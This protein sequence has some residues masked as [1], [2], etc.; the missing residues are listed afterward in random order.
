MSS[1]SAASASV[2][3]SSP[4]VDSYIG[5][6]IS[7]TSK[8]EIRYE[9]VLANINPK[10]STIALQNVK[11]FGT[12]GR[13][14][15]GP[16]IPP[17]DKVYEYILFRGTDIKDLQVKSSS[18][19]N[20]KQPVETHNDPAI[21]QSHYVPAPTTHSSAAPAPTT[22][23]SSAAPHGDGPLA[24]PGSKTAQQDFPRQPF[25][26]AYSMYHAGSHLSSWAPSPA[27][28]IVDGPM[29]Y[30]GYG[31]SSSSHA[32]GHQSVPFQP[33]TPGMQN[34]LQYPE[35][36]AATRMPNFPETA[37]SLA[38][39]N[40]FAVSN[41]QYSSSSN[42]SLSSSLPSHLQAM[43]SL[44]SS[45][46]D[47]NTMGLMFSKAA[48]AQIS[49][50][51]VPSMPFSL[52]SN[53]GSNS[54]P[55]MTTLPPLL[56]PDHLTKSLPGTTSSHDKLYPEPNNMGAL[57]PSSMH[58][59]SAVAGTPQ[60][61]LLPPPTS[62]QQGE[63]GAA[64]FSEE[65]DFTAMNEKFKKDEVWG[66]LGKEKQSAATGDGAEDNP[67]RHNAQAYEDYAPEPPKPGSKPV[68]NKDDFFDTISCNSLNRGG[69]SGRSRL[70]ERM[71]L[72]SE[73]FGEFQPRPP[74]GHG[75]Y[76]GPHGYHRG[77]FNRGRGYGYYGGRGRGGY[78][79]G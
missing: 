27:L 13:K 23:S 71:R 44:A 40:Q 69:W 26:D 49:Q 78:R 7:L 75:N 10:E 76:G 50:I 51:P 30:Q 18:S 45:N 47:L 60:E 68:Y 19:V 77:S 54:S 29:H 59:L 67:I 52:P 65:F 3:S 55:S 12:E 58:P 36:H 70:S 72:D 21:I 5:S 35:A 66:S 73:T 25:P 46:Q 57:I 64:R 42:A 22:H 9:G 61:P 48:S 15:E 11:S 33:H 2:A 6:V 39:P 43:P 34:P 28:A 31:G 79:P 8:S 17:S 1:S 53:L 14:K 56:T 20:A 63:R 32:H 74:M 38:F 62:S 24:G 4:S 41:P 16:Q 37:T